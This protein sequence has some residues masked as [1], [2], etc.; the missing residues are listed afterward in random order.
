MDD[1]KPSEL[2]SFHAELPEPKISAA[3]HLA[4]TEK[5]LLGEGV[6]RHGGR[7]E[8]GIGSKFHALHPAHK[9][10]LAA[11]EHL[12]EVEAAHVTA[13]KHLNDAAANLDRA[14]DR[15]EATAEASDTVPTEEAA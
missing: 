4:A 1:E 11:I 5:R 10:H 14:L 7:P 12:V 2:E 8:R 3:E 13:E 15:V 9:A 6:A